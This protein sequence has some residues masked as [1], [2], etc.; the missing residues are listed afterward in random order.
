MMSW[1]VVGLPVVLLVGN[2]AIRLVVG[3]PSP[4]LERHRGACDGPMTF[5]FYLQPTMAAIA[6]FP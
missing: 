3:S 5:R 6:A 1:L 2:R 4:L